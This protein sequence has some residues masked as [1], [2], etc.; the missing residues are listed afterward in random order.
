MVHINNP[1]LIPRQICSTQCLDV[2]E[3]VNISKG[4]RVNISSI[5]DIAFIFFE[6]DV[7]NNLYCIQGVMNAFAIQL[8]YSPS[9]KVL[10]PLCSETFH[11]FPDLY[12]LHGQIWSECYAQTIFFSIDHLRQ[13]V[14]RFLFRYGELQRLFP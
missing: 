11:C 2:V 13:E 1:P 6:A 10:E 9:R 4:A 12:P 7:N 14:W 3:L 8:K 5:A